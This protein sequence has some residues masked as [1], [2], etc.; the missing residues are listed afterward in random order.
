MNDRYHL[1]LGGSR[2][3]ATMDT[4]VS[5]YL[6]LHLKHPPRTRAAHS[7][8]REFLQARIDATNTAG[9]RR[10]SQWLLGQVLEVLARPSIAAAYGQ[11]Q[12][13]A[14]LSGRA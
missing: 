6:A 11:W 13:D 3:T 8:V 7:A 1:M 10:I 14:V 2:T 5:D 4:V 9:Q 12:T